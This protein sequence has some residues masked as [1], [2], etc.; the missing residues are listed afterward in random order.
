MDNLK[1]CPFC[2]MPAK[3]KQDATGSWYLECSLCGV[4][5]GYYKTK[6]FAVDA[7][8]T[9][10]GDKSAEKINKALEKDLE[11]IENKIIKVEAQRD[12]LL[13]EL[14]RLADCS[15]CKFNTPDAVDGCSALMPCKDGSM[16]EWKGV[17]N[18][19]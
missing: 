14:Q 19:R 8:N 7:W 9:R 12:A 3:A 15:S 6:Q 16:W 13:E 4:F 17:K 10:N 2:G 11:I 1:N 5:K 18:E